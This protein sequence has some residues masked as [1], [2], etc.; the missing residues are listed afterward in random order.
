MAEVGV[1]HLVRRKNGVA[2]FERFLASYREHPAGAPHDLVLVFKGFPLGRGT[3]DY[4]RLLTNVPHRR[5]YL[6]DYG[7]DLRPYFKAVAALEHRY[8]CFFNSFSRI[9]GSDWLTRL[10]F[11][12][13]AKG[14]GIVGATASYQSFSTS[15]AERDRMLREKNL[16]TR[17]RWRIGHVF[18]D[19]Q[20]RLVLQRG[21]AW[22]LGAAGLWDPTRHFPSFPNY[23]I[24]TNA[25]IASREALARVRIGPMFFKLSAYTFESGRDSLT[26][27]I[28]R[29]GLRP[30]VVGRDG[31]GYEKEHWHLANIFWQGNQENL[32]VA[33]N[34]T[35]LYAMADA[36]GR[37][38]LSRLAWGEHAR[39]A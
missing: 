30:L 22:L 18:K 29:L 2:P 10:H 36:G 32:L 20:A 3:Q 24:R 38:E 11:W 4:D 5:I 28:M 37:A 17:M 16:A 33:D 6:A 7:F 9:L 8:L 31:I 19:R 1:V 34:Q 15:S 12:A 39:P 26:N 35:D 25:F 14:V 21:A 27:Q 13:S 23:H